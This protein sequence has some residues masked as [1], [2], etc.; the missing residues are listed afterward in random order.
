MS[1]ADMTAPEFDRHML[2][3]LICPQTHSV[4]EYDSEAQELVSRNAGL[5]FPI[6]SGIPILLIDEARRLD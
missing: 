3:A 6:R 5:A 1:D 4:L 2:E